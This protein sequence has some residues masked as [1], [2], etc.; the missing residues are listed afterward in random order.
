[1]QQATLAT[2]AAKS[3]TGETREQLLDRI[4]ARIRADVAGGLA[5]VAQTA[6]AARGERPDGAGVVAAGG[7]RARA[8]RR[9]SSAR[10]A[11][12]APTSPRRSTPRCRTTSACPTARTSARL[13]DTLTDEAIASCARRWTAPGPATRCSR[14]V[15]AGQRRLRL[16]QPRLD[17]VRDRRSTCAPSAPW[18]PPPPAAVRRRCRTRSRPRFLEGLR[19]SGI[20]LGVDQ[21]AA[22]AGVLTS[23]AR[24]E[25]LVGPGRDRE[26][27]RR[28]RRSPAAG[29]TPPCTV[30]R[31]RGG[32]S[33][34]RPRR[35]PPTSSPPR[36]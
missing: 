19:A 22:V 29:P 34:W 5:G 27:V 25:S 26:V 12:P 18:S 24:V 30:A 32:C 23:G 9:C 33:G 35:S 8:R 4:D 6:L 20:E 21:A 16:R 17:A 36:A 13:L 11:G 2:R 15:A 10:R 3:H 14:R 1:M 31:R 28:R 7:D